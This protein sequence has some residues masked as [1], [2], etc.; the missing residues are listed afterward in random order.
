VRAGTLSLGFAVSWLAV[1]CPVNKTAA[2]SSQ[3]AGFD[4]TP[5][6]LR[7]SEIPVARAVTPMDLLALRDVKGLSISPDGK[8]VAFVVGQAVDETNSY[9]SGLF[10]VAT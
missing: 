4:R 10:V 8:Y 6:I 3:G 1:C 9:R 5:V 2:Q 7:S